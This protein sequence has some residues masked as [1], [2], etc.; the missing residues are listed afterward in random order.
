MYRMNEAHFT[1]SNSIRHT[2][3]TKR[4]LKSFPLLMKGHH[5]TDWDGLECFDC[6]FQFIHVRVHAVLLVNGEGEV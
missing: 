3:V 1:G 5:V 2:I 6:G 4:N